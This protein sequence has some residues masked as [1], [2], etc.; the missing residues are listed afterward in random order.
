MGLFPPR[1]SRKEER[2]WRVLLKGAP[3]KAAEQNLTRFL[4]EKLAVS[5]EDALAIV[6][7]APLVL[8]EERTK[9]EAEQIQT[10]LTKE[11]GVR[12]VVTRDPEEIRNLPRVVWPKRVSLSLLLKEQVP[13]KEA[14]PPPPPPR[15][16]PLPP[17]KPAKPTP[18]PVPP[19]PT[20]PVAERAPERSPDWKGKYEGLQKSYLEGVGR[21]EKNET[22]LQGLRKKILDLE[23][24]LRKLSEEK[25]GLA[26]ERD[27]FRNRADALAKEKEERVQ[28]Q[29]AFE[30]PLEELRQETARLKDQLQSVAQERD[31]FAS[32]RDRLAARIQEMETRKHELEKEF[33]AFKEEMERLR[34]EELID[35]QELRSYFQSREPLLELEK[36]RTRLEGELTA[37]RREREELEAQLKS[38]D[39]ILTQQKPSA[40][41]QR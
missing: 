21:L 6:R 23:G 19:K 37:S 18:A 11:T 29:K 15:K 4:K 16:V 39:G 31:H 36:T 8:F 28:A 34:R 1:P 10:L 32:E 9:E 2:S 3:D 30:K 14:A 40:K 33:A 5:E 25:N 13:L 35:I 12:V 20:P 24:E 26:R 7:S 22:E 17:P 38:V 27:T 41:A